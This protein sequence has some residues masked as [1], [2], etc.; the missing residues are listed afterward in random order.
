MALLITL[1][2]LLRGPNI[3]QAPLVLSAKI[4]WGSTKTEKKLQ[5]WLGDHVKD[6]SIVVLSGMGGLGKTALAANVYKG[7]RK[8]YDCH[9]WISVSQTYSQKDLLRKLFM[10]LLHGEAIAP[11]DIDTMD[12][13][14]IQDE[15]RKFLAQKK[16]L[17]VLDDVWKQ[18]SFSDLLGA[19]APYTKGSSIVITTRSADV[20]RLASEGRELKIECLPD[21]KAQELFHRKAFRR[22]EDYKCPTELKYHSEQI[23]AKCKGLPLAIVSV[24]SLLFVREK[25][26]TEWKRIHDQLGW[27]LGYNPGL[28]HV[29]NILHLSFIYLPTYLKSC[30]LYCALFPEDYILHRK[31]LIRLWIAEGFIEERGDSTLEEVAEGY[32]NELVHR[33]MLQPEECNSF[34]RIRSCKMHDIVRQLA[35]DLS[36]KESF[37]LA[38]E[39]GNHGILDTNTRRLAVSKCRNDI[40]LHLQLPR[41]RSCIIFDEAMPSSRIL[42]SVADKSKYIVVLELRGLSVEKV[43]SAVGYLF[44]LCY[45]GL[46][47]S[48]VKIL[49][50][51]I[52][53]LSKLLTLDIVNNMIQ[54]LPHGIVKL[55]NLRHLLV[56]RI[57]DPSHRSF[58]CRH[59]MRIR[60]GLSNLTNLQTLNTIEAQ[61]DSIKELGE[62]RQLRNLR[63]CNMKET[64]CEQFCSS[65]LEMQLLNQLHISMSD[66]DEVLKL[67]KLKTLHSLQKLI[68][69]GRL[70]EGTLKS[71]LFQEGGQKLHG[72][73]LVWSCL[74]E[75]P[76]P[77]ISRLSNL[78]EMH[79]T[80]AYN[81][82]KLVFSKEWFPK[83]KSLALRD[84]PHLNEL[85]IEEGALASI[86]IFQLVN[87]RKLTVVP[88]GL[89]F[90]ASLQRLSFLQITEEFHVLLN[91][92]SRIQH[93]RWQYST[94][95]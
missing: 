19:F 39:Y 78:T 24:G 66:E 45:L 76:L 46:R 60:K 25:N 17:I 30:F 3:L 90:L 35:I 40:W 43:P 63:I 49:P 26:P 71:P 85:V 88:P 47:D 6:C 5:D 41:L 86:H 83:L 18:E 50:K 14:G 42:D 75:D 51:S 93:I 1:P 80:S 73:Y 13:P 59:G 57:V 36:R 20:A 27:E 12:I 29:R 82:G 89:E 52:E 2:L 28:D 81:G 65:L 72:L 62:L 61:D 11:V 33:N 15:L 21:D 23:V 9:A 32:L 56:E 91:E 38:Y 54:E 22:E 34:R 77:S 16:Y 44:N 92:C 64:H 55:K 95:D 58:I 48:K 4:L 79:L 7:E 87:L 31:V 8:N 84:L 37:G 68:V 53:K 94:Q 70:A 67:N 10:D 69:R 74:R